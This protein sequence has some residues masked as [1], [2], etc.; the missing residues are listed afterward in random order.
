MARNGCALSWAF[1]KSMASRCAVPAP[2][3]GYGSPGRLKWSCIGKRPKL[4]SR[5]MTSWSI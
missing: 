2:T 3:K 1:K 4:T 5:Q